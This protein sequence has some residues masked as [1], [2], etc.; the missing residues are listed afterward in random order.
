MRIALI[1]LII[2]LAVTGG[3][4]LGWVVRHRMDRHREKEI[5][6]GLAV[7]G[8]QIDVRDEIDLRETR[9]VEDER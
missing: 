7:Q 9:S 3:F 5:R 1:I 6:D 4:A 2:W 8:H